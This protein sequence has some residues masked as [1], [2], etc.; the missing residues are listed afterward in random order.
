MS[1]QRRY[2]CIG[3]AISEGIR[4]ESVTEAIDDAMLDARLDAQTPKPAS[5]RLQRQPLPIRKSKKP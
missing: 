2:L 4:C 1:H 3:N 5:D